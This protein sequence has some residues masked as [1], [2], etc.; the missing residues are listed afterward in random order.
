MSR[1]V[2]CRLSDSDYCG[3]SRGQDH[4]LVYCQLVLKNYSRPPPAVFADAIRLRVLVTKTPRFQPTPKLARI[5]PC[6]SPE[7]PRLLLPVL[8]LAGV[9]QARLDLALLICA[10]APDLRVLDPFPLSLRQVSLRWV[11]RRTRCLRRDVRIL[12][13][14]TRPSM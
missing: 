3:E 14:N 6:P 1:Y 13:L 8:G 4:R 9:V 7:W 2:L 10:Q 11:P 12:L 5:S